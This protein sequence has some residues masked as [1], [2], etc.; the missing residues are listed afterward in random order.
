MVQKTW[1]CF[2]RNCSLLAFQRNRH[3]HLYSYIYSYVLF[4]CVVGLFRVIVP[5]KL[6]SAF[7]RGHGMLKTAEISTESAFQT[8]LG[9]DITPSFDLL[10]LRPL[11]RL[12]PWHC[13]PPSHSDPAAGR[14]P[15]LSRVTDQRGGRVPTHKCISN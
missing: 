4:V 5:K 12:L 2:S 13:Y 8:C 7:K 3:S 14:H 1:I 11:H 9:K 10:I 6:D 15:H